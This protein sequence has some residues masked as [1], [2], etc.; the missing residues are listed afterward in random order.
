M[1]PHP[2]VLETKLKVPN[3]V[4]ECPSVLYK[5]RDPNATLKFRIVLLAK[6]KLPHAVFYWPLILLTKDSDPKAELE[7]F[8][9]KN[10]FTENNE[11]II[12]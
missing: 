1:L 9:R 7:L 4:F 11:A 8:N 2:V 12:I 5:E 6:E 3:A 10:V